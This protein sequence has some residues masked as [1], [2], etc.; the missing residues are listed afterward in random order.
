MCPPK[1]TYKHHLG[2][3]VATGALSSLQLESVIYACQRFEGPR[4]P[5]SGVA[6]PTGAP[7]ASS[8]SSVPPRAGFFLGDGAGVGKGRQIAGLAYEHWFTG[9]K[10][11]LWLSVSGDL[12]HDAARD[13]DD[14]G[15]AQ[16]PLYPARGSAGGTVPTGNLD[17]AGVKDGVLFMTYSLL[18]S[19]SAKGTR[20]DQ[21]VK[22]LGNCP[23][24]GLI[25]F[26]E[27][28]KAKNLLPP[29]AKEV[30]SDAGRGGGRGSRGGRGAGGERDDAKGTTQTARTVVLLQERLPHAKV[31][32][33]SAT[34][35]SVPRNLA[36]MVRLGAFGFPS[37][38][39]FLE[40]LTGA[41]LGSLE[42]FSMGL[43]ATGTYLC[44]TL[45]YAGAEFEL[46][47]VP[48]TGAMGTMYDRSSEFWVM[49]SGLFTEVAAG[50]G[51]TGRNKGFR[52]AQFWSARPVLARALLAT[53]GACIVC[54]LMRGLCVRCVLL[55]ARTSAS[56]AR[57]SSPPRCRCWPSRLRTPSPTKARSRTRAQVHRSSV[58]LNL[59]MQLA[60]FAHAHASYPPA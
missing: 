41:G 26:D 51:L 22:W 38:P 23:Q 17:A 7:G 3:A 1:P 57:C 50:S 52:M 53:A 47:H 33:A 21:V 14:L 42:L 46:E 32:Y 37:F 58:H 9:G 24:G 54:V 43:K 6:A 55:Q 16:L 49:L 12:R 56:S 27:C 13:I 5:L 4:L 15:L 44:R 18:I 20:L 48:L 25:V 45:S 10:R 8:S 28:H 19:K 60:H 11:V 36:Y 40:T 34:G 39:S 2:A 30:G 35:A 29:R 59:C 31:V